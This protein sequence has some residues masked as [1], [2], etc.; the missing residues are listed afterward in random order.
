MMI[1]KISLYD[2]FLVLYFLL[3]P[4]NNIT[5]GALGSGFK[6][7]ALILSVVFL[8]P[9]LKGKTININSTIRIWIVYLFV[10]TLSLAWTQ[11]FER[12]VE[13]LIG[14]IEV[15]L[16]TLLL[17]NQTYSYN[18]KIYLKLAVI[19]SG[20]IYLFFLFFF[21]EKQIYTDRSIISFGVFGQMDPNEWCCYM[22]APSVFALSSFFQ[23]EINTFF[24]G[25]IFAYLLL[26]IYGCLLSGS[27]G[28]LIAV[29]VSLILT[30]LYYLK[31]KPKYFFLIIF[32]LFLAYFVLAYYIWPLL[33][34]TLT[35]RFSIQSVFSNG[36]SGRTK[37]W[38][39]SINYLWDNLARLFFGCGIFGAKEIPFTSHNQYLQVLVDNGI[40]GLLL[41]MA[42]LIGLL[43][44]A[45]KNEIFILISFI[46][47][48]FALFSLTGYA[49]F[50]AI[51]SIYLLVLLRFEKSNQS[52]VIKEI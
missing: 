19:G 35:G 14:M 42:L 15:F 6:Y 26:I 43:K 39:D 5:L 27:R 12:S 13:C 37:I 46:G 36:G 47:I 32:V 16:I 2:I 8:F 10:C 44:K 28:G 4:L 9:L 21:G 48:Q 50:K 31:N 23:K 33:P 7:L 11:N 41:Y 34:E 51:W 3:I 20:L 40:F 17:Q 24:K 49:W 18:T 45:L 1:K 38:L 30:L 25:L 29:V 52:N 22:I